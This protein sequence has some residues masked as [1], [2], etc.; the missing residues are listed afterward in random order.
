M[1]DRYFFRQTL[2]DGL[3]CHCLSLCHCLVKHGLCLLLGS[4]RLGVLHVIVERPELQLGCG[5]LVGM[6]ESVGYCLRCSL[7][8]R[9]GISMLV[10]L[11]LVPQT[12]REVGECHGAQSLSIDNAPSSAMEH[13]SARS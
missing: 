3:V 9:C 10:A 8:L 1:L 6:S 13:H 11:S 12:T 7:F 5:F 4:V 2:L